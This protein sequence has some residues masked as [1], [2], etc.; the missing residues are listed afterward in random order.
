MNRSISVLFL[1]VSL[2][3]GLAFFSSSCE[4]DTVLPS[5]SLSPSARS[6]PFKIYLTDDPGDY[7]QVNI[8]LAEVQVKI[9]DSTNFYTLQ[10][11]Q[12][13]YDLLQLQ[14]GLDTLVVFDSLP[15]G[16]LQEIRLVL[17]ANN[18]IM[19]DSV[20]HDL[21]VP[22]GSTSGLKIKTNKVLIQDSLAALTVDFDAGAS[23]VEKGNGTFSLKPVIR[24]MP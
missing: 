16:E 7:D 21:K 6:V 10:T 23:I 4:S 2:L 17:G 11:Y 14:N 20:L 22:S 19:V 1:S 18:S 15:P 5:D 3:V 8:D 9:K 12:G 13:I 24:V